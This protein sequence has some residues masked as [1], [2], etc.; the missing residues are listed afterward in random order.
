[1]ALIL[2]A[3]QKLERAGLIAFF[4]ETKD[5]WCKMAARAHAH[6]KEQYPENAPIRPDD[7]AKILS[8]VLGVDESLTEYLSAE[9]LRQRYWYTHF[10]DLIIDRC[11]TEFA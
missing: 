11:W 7:V 8:P 10:T 1:M 3:E 2:E 6:L 5:D 4:E 9:Q